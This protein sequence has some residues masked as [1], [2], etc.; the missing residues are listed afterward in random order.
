MLTVRATTVRRCR[1]WRTFRTPWSRAYSRTLPTLKRSTPA[2]T[3][4]LYAAAVAGEAGKVRQLL[5]AGADPNRISEGPG[6]GTPLRAAACW[7]YLETVDALLSHGADPN[8]PEDE[9]STPRDWAARGMY[10]DVARSLLAAGAPDG[11]GAA[12]RD[13]AWFS[14]ACPTAG[15]QGAGRRRRLPDRRY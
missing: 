7:G 11:F 3:T 2:G 1:W 12:D 13:R 6:E 5:E 9:L 10:A 15:A 4:T 14:L 8:L